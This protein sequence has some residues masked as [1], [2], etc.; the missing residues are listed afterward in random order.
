MCKCVT[1]MCPQKTDM[2]VCRMCDM[3][4]HTQCGRWMFTPNTCVC[5]R[6]VYSALFVHT[7]CDMHVFSQC[8]TCM[9]AYNV[10]CPYNVANM[11]AMYNMH[12]CV[13]S[14]CTD[15]MHDIHVWIM[16][17]MHMCTQWHECAHK[18]TCAQ[19]VWHTTTYR[20]MHVQTWLYRI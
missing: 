12:M 15:T 8:V 11:C 5:V 16:C 2:H 1:L 4:L 3:P 17:D 19:N 6:H 20:D 14:M 18:H 7:I 13:T 10:T 9:C